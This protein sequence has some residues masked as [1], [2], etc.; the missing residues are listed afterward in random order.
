MNLE[1]RLRES[2]RFHADRVSAAPDA[3]SEIERGL[4]PGGAPPSPRQRVLVAAVALVIAIGAGLF[5]WKAFGGGTLHTAAI[6][7]GD[8]ILFSVR[9]DDTGDTNILAL[10]PGGRSVRPFVAGPTSDGDASLSPDGSRVA[11]SRDGDIFVMN[12]DG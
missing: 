2:M 6:S 10:S 9:N 8:T 12:V 1:D 3:W 7:P 11:F 5:V 4:R